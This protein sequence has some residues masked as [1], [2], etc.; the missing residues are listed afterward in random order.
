[1][2]KSRL[3]QVRLTD[4]QF[5]QITEKAESNYQSISEYAREILLQPEIEIVQ[6]APESQSVTNIPI[7][8]RPEFLK[9]VVWI[10]SKQNVLNND[11]SIEEA[12][13]IISLIDSFIMD[14]EPK[15][16]DYFYNVKKDLKRAI[17]EHS[18]FFG[19][20]YNF[21]MSNDNAY[22]NYKDF[23]KML[24]DDIM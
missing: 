21:N 2:K 10:Y 5:D 14:L 6:E 23:E 7:F 18:S 20:V 15:Y 8:E 9:V 17:K 16:L 13:L 1:M 12:N 4:I 22:F 3:I 24:L 11:N 19:V